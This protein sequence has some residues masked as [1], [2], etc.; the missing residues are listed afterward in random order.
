MD[1]FNRIRSPPIEE[2][3]G[4]VGLDRPL[5]MEQDADPPSASIT[6]SIE[7]SEESKDGFVTVK[8]SK[9]LKSKSSSSSLAAAAGVANAASVVPQSS[10]TS[11][12]NAQKASGSSNG[13]AAK[14]GGVNPPTMA[15]QRRSSRQS[16]NPGT[17]TVEYGF[18]YTNPTQDPLV[19]IVLYKTEK[20]NRKPCARTCEKYHSVKE[21]RRNPLAYDYSEQPCPAV[22]AGASSRAWGDP[23]KCPAG[24]ECQFSHTL[25]E[26]MYHPNI[27]KTGMCNKYS[28]DPATNNCSWSALCTHAH[29]PQ[30][31][32]RQVRA[33][34]KFRELIEAGVNEWFIEN[35]SQDLAAQ[36]VSASLVP[37]S[38]EKPPM[39][40]QLSLTD[41]PAVAKQSSLDL[42]LRVEDEDK[43]SSAVNDNDPILRT[44]VDASP[45]YDATLNRPTGN[46]AP[47]LS[48]FS[49]VNVPSAKPGLDRPASTDR[50]PIGPAKRGS[51]NHSMTPKIELI[52][53]SPLTQAMSLSAL[54]MMSP[55]SSAQKPSKLERAM[56]GP[57]AVTRNGG[58]AA[59]GASPAAHAPGLNFPMLNRPATVTT[60]VGP[61]SDGIWGNFS[62]VRTSWETPTSS[63]EESKIIMQSSKTPASGDAEDMKRQVERLQS[64]TTCPECMS[65]DRSVVLVPCRHF[66]CH[67]CAEQSARQRLCMQCS[68]ECQATLAVR[69]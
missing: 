9:P 38:A 65:E 43:P 14:A 67:R 2:Y 54:P 8:S 7:S 22:K 24:D 59:F 39:V 36:A 47:F 40:K 55:S 12:V 11:V 68:E 29:G 35:P 19:Y 15:A 42:H 69:L 52:S 23:A 10:A 28:P 57:S 63:N 56:S 34:T 46:S 32:D 21:R 31:R 58:N 41:K 27:Y 61:A 13:Y 64:K 17:I 60:L 44:P 45:A 16:A 20:C 6:A 33:L 37:V 1:P 51:G 25:L 30:D 66:L 18:R 48:S 49:N 5:P 50:N 26:Q 3:F 62:Y 4:I 53:N